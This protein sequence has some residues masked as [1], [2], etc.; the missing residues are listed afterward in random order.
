MNLGQFRS[1]YLGQFTFGN[2]VFSGYL[3]V[4]RNTEGNP[5]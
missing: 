5:Q 4:H 1:I 2:M 3:R